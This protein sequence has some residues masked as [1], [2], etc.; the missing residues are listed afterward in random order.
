M[1]FQ[2]VLL[3]QLTGEVFLKKQTETSRLLA[4]KD[5][6]IYYLIAHNHILS[7]IKQTNE[8]SP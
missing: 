4:N 7:P 6:A 2:T 3:S 8:W 5:G 1:F